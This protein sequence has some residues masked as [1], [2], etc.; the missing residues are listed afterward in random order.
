[1]SPNAD[2][3]LG[4]VY[5]VVSRRKGKILDEEI[6][7]GTSFFNVSATIPVAESFGFAE[8][9]RTKT[10]GGAN[11]LLIFSGYDEQLWEIIYMCTCTN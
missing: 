4:K 7:E 11:P 3:V 1:M 6:R 9:I 8:E 5:G 2:D 10:S